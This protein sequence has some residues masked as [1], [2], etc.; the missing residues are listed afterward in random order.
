MNMEK[1]STLLCRTKKTQTEA[2]GEVVSRTHLRVGESLEY[3][4]HLN[5]RSNRKT[6]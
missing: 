6:K 1:K 4:K 3:R 5:S 2:V